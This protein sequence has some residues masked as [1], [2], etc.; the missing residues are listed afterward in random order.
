MPFKR[1]LY[2][3]NWPEIAARIKTAAGWHC[4]QCGHPHDPA[5][6]YGLGVHHI[7]GDRANNTD[8]NLVALCQRCHLALHARKLVGQRMFEFAWPTWWRKRQP[9]AEHAGE[10]HD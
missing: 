9:P 2:P 3:R 4:E 6:Y 8:A 7:D 5:G 1:W 10:K